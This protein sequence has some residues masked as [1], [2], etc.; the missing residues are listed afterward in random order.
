M[1]V[2]GVDRRSSGFDFVSRFD[3]LFEYWLS[4]V[5]LSAPVVASRGVRLGLGAGGS[6]WGLFRSRVLYSGIGGIRC[7]VLFDHP[8]DMD[9]IIGCFPDGVLQVDGG[10]F[11]GI[12]CPM[13]VSSLFGSD[14][15]GLGVGVGDG[16]WVDIGVDFRSGLFVVDGVRYVTGVV[17]VG[18]P[19]RAG[20]FFRT[21]GLSL[22]GMEIA[23]FSVVG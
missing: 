19:F 4:G 15:V 10:S 5:Q 18:G 2:R 20:V 17:P 21:N 16:V 11:W 8:S 12:R 22:A 7:R 23:S 1:P 14:G 13:G 6:G 3:S 9:V